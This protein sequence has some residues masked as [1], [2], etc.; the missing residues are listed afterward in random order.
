MKKLSMLMAMILVIASWSIVKAQQPEPST[1]SLSAQATDTK[2]RYLLETY[3]TLK[4]GPSYFAVNGPKEKPNT[5]F[6]PRFLR[7]DAQP[8][9]GRLPIRFVKIV[10]HFNGE[11]A[12][13]R[14]SVLRGNEGYEEEEFL[15]TYQL[16]VGEQKSLTHLRQVG[17][18][19]FLVRLVDAT[20]PLPAEPEFKNFTKSIEIVSVR[21]EHTPMPAYRITLRNL[22]DKS[23]SGLKVDV[24]SDGEEGP[25]T[26]PDGPEGRALVDPGGLVDIYLPVIVAVRKAAN[27][28]PGTP[29]SNTINIRNVSFTDLSFEGEEN[30]ACSF[31][32]QV[33]GERIWLRSMIAFID[34]ELA[35]S[36]FE[37]QI[38]AAK[39]FNEKL[40]KIRQRLDES[41]R[42]K[43]SSVSPNCPKPAKEATIAARQRNL[44]LLREVDQFIVAPPAPPVTFKSWLEEKRSRYTAWL[45]RL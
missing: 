6:Y 26:L 28:A 20:L 36:N 15:H 5:A 29:G 43:P 19:P 9:P 10:P 34:Q 30:Q 41:E 1:P 7:T 16:A 12:D 2:G 27:Y 21:R 31:E 40:S 8:E 14:V 13:I 24:T 22:S 17:I 18:E 38:E 42:D 33:I 37:D 23:V 39:Q 4:L 45:A 25:I 32:A 3:I 44:L 35:T 11:T